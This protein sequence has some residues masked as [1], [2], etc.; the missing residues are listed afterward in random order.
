MEAAH[1]PIVQDLTAP[2]VPEKKVA[3]ETGIESENTDTR[4]DI[5]HAPT[6]TGTKGRGLAFNTT[7]FLLHSVAVDKLNRERSSDL[8]MRFH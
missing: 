6:L 2:L 4:K 3:I 8:R 5:A 7:D 1:P